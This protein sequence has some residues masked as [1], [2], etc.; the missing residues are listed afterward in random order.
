[1][2]PLRVVDAHNGSVE[3]KIRSPGGPVNQW[4]QIY[5]T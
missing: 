1:M 5:M 2:E 3:A 4:S